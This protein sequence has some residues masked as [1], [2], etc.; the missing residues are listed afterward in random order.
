MQ[1]I[2]SRETSSLPG[3]VDRVND[4]I[5]K[6][7][8]RYIILFVLIYGFY[9]ILH[10]HVSPGGGFAGG[11]V[12]GLGIMLYFLVFGYPWKVGTRRLIIDLAIDRKS[13]RLNS[14]HVR[15]SYAVFCLKKK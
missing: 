3:E 7:V 6:V 5:T 1:N 10:G 14:S 13:T 2:L 8:F 11:M 12:V 9:I 15:I 4:F